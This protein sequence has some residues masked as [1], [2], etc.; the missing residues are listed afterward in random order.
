MVGFPIPSWDSSMLQA[1]AWGPLA[2]IQRSLSIRYQTLPG[3]AACTRTACRNRNQLSDAEHSRTAPSTGRTRS[4]ENSREAKAPPSL[5]E[6]PG[7]RA[8]S[9]RLALEPPPGFSWKDLRTENLAEG[10]AGVSL[11]WLPYFRL[12]A[13]CTLLQISGCFLRT[14]QGNVLNRRSTILSVSGAV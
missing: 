13:W 7:A 12:R 10:Q 8:R 14:P 2:Q 1:G 3:T 4:R 9:W 5:R 6:A 11:G